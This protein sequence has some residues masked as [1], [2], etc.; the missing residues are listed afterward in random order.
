MGNILRKEPEILE[1]HQLPNHYKNLIMS[2]EALPGIKVGQN[3]LNNPFNKIVDTWHGIFIF[4]TVNDT[5]NEGLFFLARCLSN[6]YWE[7][8]HKWRI[9]LEV[10]DQTSNDQPRPLTYF[11]YRPILK[12]D[13]VS[14][15]EISEEF[16][17]LI[18]NMNYHYYHEKF[19]IDF[20]LNKDSYHLE[21]ELCFDRNIKLKDLGV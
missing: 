14:E 3:N 7:H 13:N 1:L 21:D 8:G 6:R 4:F 16:Q 18:K 2:I 9:E 10:G 19:M 5:N 20:K 15:S 12:N 11:I 17:S